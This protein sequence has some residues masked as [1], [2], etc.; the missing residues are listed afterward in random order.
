VS[1]T[2]TVGKYYET[3]DGDVVGPMH[4]SEDAGWYA[5]NTR[6]PELVVETYS[7]A[8]EVLLGVRSVENLRREWRPPS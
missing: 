8:G 4:Y 6:R 5:D 7:P 1:P 3:F 2:L